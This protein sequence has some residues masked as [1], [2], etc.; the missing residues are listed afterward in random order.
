LWDQFAAL[1]PARPVVDPSHS[2]RCHRPSVA[3][4]IVFDKLLQVLRFGCSYEGIADTTRAATTIRNRHDEWIHLGVFA[5]LK[6]IVLDAYDRIVGLLRDD[7]AIDG[8]IAPG[9]TMPLFP[10]CNIEGGEGIGFPRTPGDAGR[11]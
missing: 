4:R 3:D 1:L 9:F 5:T 6:Q 7:L 11:I 2:L 8:C 10:D